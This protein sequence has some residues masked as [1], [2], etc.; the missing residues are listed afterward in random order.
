MAFMSSTAHPEGQP[1]LPARVNLLGVQVD[2]VTLKQAVEHIVRSVRLGQG[3]WVITPNLDILR[4]LVVDQKFAEL[5]AGTTLRLADGMPLVWAGK[6]QGTPLP[7]RVA[8]SDLIWNLTQAAAQSGAS[9]YLLGG[10]PGA[11]EAAGAKFAELYPGVRIVGA[12]CPPVGFEKDAA[13][14]AALR[15]RLRAAQPS[16]VFVALGCPK[17]E[18]VA[19]L[20]RPDLPEAWFLGV[21]ISFSF[22]SGEVKR[23]PSWMRKVGLEWF[24]RMLQEPGRLFRRYMI[25]GVPFAL[26]LFAVSWW[27]GRFGKP[28]SG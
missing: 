19:S 24:H 2:A 17:Q 7:E 9:I 25:D 28:A 14:M 18:L 12:E 26:R 21:G 8:G 11:A 27:R 10:N 22:V 23:A 16:I 1:R 5:V 4:R 20:L 3:G 15:D 13:Y 6:L